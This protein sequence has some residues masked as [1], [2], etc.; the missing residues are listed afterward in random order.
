MGLTELLEDFK[1]IR[2]KFHDSRTTDLSLVPIRE[3]KTT[4]AGIWRKDGVKSFSERTL[5]GESGERRGGKTF[6]QHFDMTFRFGHQG[7][8]GSSFLRAGLC[9][10]VCTYRV[11]ATWWGTHKC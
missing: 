11:S 2:E 1:L 7:N 9:L 6:S 5:T 4:M 10:G 8:L 3:T